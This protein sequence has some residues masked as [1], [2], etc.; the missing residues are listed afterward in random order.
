[1]T[2]AHAG[3]FLNGLLPDPAGPG[4][5]L[6][7]MGRLER[8]EVL[9]GA[10]RSVRRAVRAL[11]LG[12]GRDVLHGRWLGHPV[13]PH[14]VQIPMGAWLSSAVL[15][16]VP[17]ARR[18]SAVLIGLGLAGATP[19]ALAGWV[20]WAE[21][22]D[23]QARVGLAHAALNALAIACY[24]GS[25]GMRLAGRPVRGRTLALAGLATVSVSGAVGGH[26]AYRQAAGAN[27][28]EAVSHLVGPGWH[29]VG[30][31]AD[32]PV[33]QPVR[34][35]LDDVALV[36]VRE[37]EAT[38]RVLADRCSHDGGPLSE[39]TLSDG[40]LLCPLHGSAFR[41]TDGWN[42][43]GPATAPQPAFDTRVTDRQV[44]VRLQ[45]EPNREV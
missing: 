30:A 26:L 44:Q 8:A 1:M 14:L 43:T 38:L 19:A 37:D 2:K 20:D 42:V 5:V 33:G 24:T 10:V 7:A 21:L 16:W 27:H 18:P 41:L 25:L 45:A 28:A 31:L 32:I 36:I 39:G 9:D 11:P 34:R 6:A 40:C 22:E 17:G 12:G 13:H 29:T 35:L 23:E 4:R 15:D 3:S